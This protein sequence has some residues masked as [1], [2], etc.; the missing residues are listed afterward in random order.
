MKILER[1]VVYRVRPKVS[2][3]GMCEHYCE[4]EKYKGICT[5]EDSPI[6]QKD[7]S[8]VREAIFPC[9]SKK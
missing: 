9:F 5:N 6:Y 7:I 3:C 2:K 4:K 8:S 1:L